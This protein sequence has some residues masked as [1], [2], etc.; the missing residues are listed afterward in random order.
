[1]IIPEIR[2]FTAPATVIDAWWQHRTPARQ[3]RRGAIAPPVPRIAQCAD[4]AASAPGLIHA[5]AERWSGVARNLDRFAP[6]ASRS[7]MSSC[8]PEML[9]SASCR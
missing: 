1:V 8:A 5:T 3:S 7:T 6:G 2:Y 9:L 4:G